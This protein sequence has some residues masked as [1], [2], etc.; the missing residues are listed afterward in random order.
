MIIPFIL[1][2]WDVWFGNSGAFTFHSRKVGT[3]LLVL[4][5]RVLVFALHHLSEL[6]ILHFV[7]GFRPSSPCSGWAWPW[8][9]SIPRLSLVHFGACVSCSTLPFLGH[10]LDRSRLFLQRS[11][12]EAGSDT[13]V[14]TDRVG[15]FVFFH[16]SSCFFSV[17]CRPDAHSWRTVFT[18]LPCT[19]PFSGRLVPLV[20]GGWLRHSLPSDIPSY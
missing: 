14:S 18:L 17:H 5:G 1:P 9:I 7:L 10:A 12:L 2:A 6:S 19:L 3:R 4:P 11:Y 13:S 20:S 8:R 16:S 15:E